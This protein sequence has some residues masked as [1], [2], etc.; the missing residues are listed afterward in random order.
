[1]TGHRA[2]LAPGPCGRRGPVAR[3]LPECC[4]NRSQLLA[5]KTVEKHLSLT[6]L[7][8]IPSGTAFSGPSRHAAL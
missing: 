8:K 1:M 6:T 7:R 5:G 3:Q 2:V 4:L